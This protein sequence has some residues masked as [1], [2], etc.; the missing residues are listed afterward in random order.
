MFNTSLYIVQK[1]I[2]MTPDKILEIDTSITP[3]S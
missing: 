3:V 1:I 2:S